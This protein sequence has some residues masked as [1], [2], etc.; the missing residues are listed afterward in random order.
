MKLK[1]F[2]ILIFIFFF[3][4]YNVFCGISSNTFS[5]TIELEQINIRETKKKLFDFN[6]IRGVF[7][8]QIFSGKKNELIILKDKSSKALNNPRITFNQTVSLNIT[9]TDDAGLQLN[10][11]GRG[12]DPKRTSNFNVRQNYYDISI[13]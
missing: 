10:I 6:F 3:F 5:D 7:N 9:E 13:Q 12:L 8:N 4:H 2:N 1:V 11:G